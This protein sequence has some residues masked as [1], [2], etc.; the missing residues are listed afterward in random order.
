MYL[1]WWRRYHLSHARVDGAGHSAV[2]CP[3]VLQRYISVFPFLSLFFLYSLQAFLSPSSLSLVLSSTPLFPPPSFHPFLQL[4]LLFLL[5]CVSSASVFSII[6]QHSWRGI[7]EQYIQHYIKGKR[8]FL[9]MGEE[10][11]ALRERKFTNFSLLN[12]ALFDKDEE[13][14]RNWREGR[15]TRRG[16]TRERNM[17]TRNCW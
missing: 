2:A 12:S 11:Q 8:D 6:E 13:R 5:L 7:Q 1:W 3:L 17:K 16:E 4:F 9:G 14:W 10:R 15:E